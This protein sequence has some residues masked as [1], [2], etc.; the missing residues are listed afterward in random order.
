MRLLIDSMA[1]F[2][3]SKLQYSPDIN[4]N[5]FRISSRGLYRLLAVP[6]FRY[7]T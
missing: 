6:V 3:P 5:P 4:L 7:H 2:P 1:R